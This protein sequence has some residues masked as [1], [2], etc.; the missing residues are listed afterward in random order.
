MSTAEQVGSA[1][2]AFAQQQQALLSTAQQIQSV[3]PQVYQGGGDRTSVNVAVSGGVLPD[4]FVS[5]TF[6]GVPEAAA[7]LVGAL[8]SGKS[9]TMDAQAVAGVWSAPPRSVQGFS[10]QV[11]YGAN[12]YQLFA[13]PPELRVAG[14][15]V[16]YAIW[17]AGG[18]GSGGTMG[19]AGGGGGCGGFQIGTLVVGQHIPVGT[20]YLLVAVGPGGGGGGPNG[21]PGGWGGGTAVALPSGA[22]IAAVGGG[23]PG[24][25]GNASYGYTP[26]GGQQYNGMNYYVSVG[27]GRY[28][29]QNG[30]GGGVGSGGGGGGSG[31]FAAPVGYWGG[32][33]GSGCAIL[34]AYLPTKWTQRYV[35]LRSN[36]AGTAFVYG[37]V[38]VPPQTSPAA[39]WWRMD[40]GA[41]VNGVHYSLGQQDISFG[42]AYPPTNLALDAIGGTKVGEP[43]TYNLSTIGLPVL[44]V[45]DTRQLT[46]AGTAYRTGGIADTDG[47]PGALANFVFYDNGPATGPVG[48]T[49]PQNVANVVNGTVA[50]VAQTVQVGPSGTVEISLSGACYNNS[51]GYNLTACVVASGANTGTYRFGTSSIW[52]AFTSSNIGGSRIINGLTPGQTSFTVTAQTNGATWAFQDLALSVIPF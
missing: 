33:G 34:T 39:T 26:P 15:R 9:A 6:S 42:T 2:A 36:A 49:T 30:T 31:T 46:M 19:A 13:L 8:F 10:Q 22:Q 11:F 41:V 47:L 32:A 45:T 40:I 18:G 35:I 16:D 12:Q 24:Y 3:L 25:P 14:A 21:S 43:A 44:M 1:A 27:G 29:G 38:W 50:P 7:G 5:K 17:G 4:G 51:G 52:A 48:T 28:T 20:E 23:N 37:R